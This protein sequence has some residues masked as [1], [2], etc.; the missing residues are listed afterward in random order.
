[1]RATLWACVLLVG[2]LAPGSAAALTTTYTD[3]SL[4]VAALPGPGTTLDLESLAP[5]T[6]LPSGST[7]GDLT[8]TYAIAGLTAKVTDSFDTTSGGNSL[9]LTGGDDAFLD[10]DELDFAAATILHAIGMYFI[11]T[12]PALAGEIQVVTSAGTASNSAT[13][14]G[15]LPDGGITYFVGLI[16][17]D[18]FTAAGVRFAA[19]GEVNFAFNIDDVTYVVPEPTTLTLWLAA[20]AAMLTGSSNRFPRLDQ[21]QPNNDRRKI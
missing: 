4:F 15:V 19:D 14:N 20:L 6:L 2:S 13:S 9:G 10:G 5:G 11:T 17:T 16:S 1:M 8:L 18:S 12:D 7:V 21:K 3:E